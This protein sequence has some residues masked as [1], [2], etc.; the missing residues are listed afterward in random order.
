MNLMRKSEKSIWSFDV[1]RLVRSTSGES[2]A[3]A[4]RKAISFQRAVAR[5][6]I[7]LATLTQAISNTSTTATNRINSGPVCQITLRSKTPVGQ[8]F[9]TSCP[10]ANLARLFLNRS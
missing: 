6:S 5:P 10:A 9:F 1:D 2:D 7:R 4:R 8:L 3:S